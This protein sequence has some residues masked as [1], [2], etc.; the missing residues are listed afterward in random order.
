VPASSPR[1]SLA[2]LHRTIPAWFIE[3]LT[4]SSGF[5]TPEIKGLPKGSEQRY[6]FVH[7]GGSPNRVALIGAH[8]TSL[9]ID[10]DKRLVIAIFA[11][12]PGDNTSG[13]LPLLDETWKAIDRAITLGT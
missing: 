13:T 6:G 2:R 3:T 4:A 9:Y 5:R 7:L 1:R 10:F 8:G 11:T 12:R